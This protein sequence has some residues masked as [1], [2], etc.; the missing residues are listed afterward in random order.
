MAVTAARRSR[1]GLQGFLRRVVLGG[2]LVAAVVIGLLA[3]HTLNLH[4][5]AAAHAPAV[6]SVSTSDAVGAHHGAAGTHESGGT[7]SDLGGTC[8]D[9]G[10]GTHLGMA[11]AC[12]LA[13][14]LVLLILVPPRLLPGWMHTAPRPL[15]VARS[16]DRLLPRAPSLHVLC[17]S[18]T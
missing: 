3:M 9:C 14:L 17:I 10:A 1:K 13:L 18:R 5:T 12:V 7:A 11:M 6:I 4:G 2:L 8:A 16:I 15:L